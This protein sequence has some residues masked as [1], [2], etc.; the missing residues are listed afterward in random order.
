MASDGDDGGAV[1]T[2]E[3]SVTYPFLSDA[4]VEEARRIR[5]EYLGRVS[6]VAELVRM[7]LVVTEVPFG[8]GQLH[9]HLDT[10]SGAIDIEIGHVDPA[11]LL[12]H[13][14]YVTARE[15]LVGGNAQAGLQAFMAGKVRVE[16]DIG[17]L[18]ALNVG[19]ADESA[20]ELA[21][22]IRAITA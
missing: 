6:A 22:R 3:R 19:P 17:K 10:S 7:N 4:W 15:I 16:G 20:Q 11:D 14:D 8:P 21:A 12:V 13:V 18:M 5:T 2:G 9:A 1:T